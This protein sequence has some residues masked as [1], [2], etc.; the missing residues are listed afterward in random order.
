MKPAALSTITI[1]LCLVAGPPH[2]FAQ[3]SSGSTGVDGALNVTSNMTLNLPP[4]G[5]FNFTTISVSNGATLTFNRNPLNTPVYMLATGDVNISGIIDVGGKN[6]N[7]IAPGTGG[8][9]GFDGGFAALQ[10]FPDGDGQGPGGGR[11]A[12]NFG[13]AF[14]SAGGSGANTNV[15]GNTLLSP[16]V[17]GSG[18]AGGFAVGFRGGGGGGGAI[19]VGSSTRVT[20][21]STGL[22]NSQGG[23]GQ[24]GGSGGAIRLVAPVVDGSGRL[25]VNAGR[26]ELTGNYTG[27]PGRT[28]ID[29][30][31][32][33]AHGN[34]TLSGKATRGSQMFVFPPG[35][36]RLDIIHA[37]GREI[38]EGTNAP[39]TVNLPVGA[40]TNQIVRIQARGFTNDIPIRVRITP[41]NA[42]SA[43]FDGVITNTGNP[44]VG[45]VTVSLP[46]DTVCYLHVWTR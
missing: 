3:F 12:L 5:I 10:G 1:G 24:G 40:S 32:R 33:F 17:G 39:V 27:S 25:D 13:A 14:A 28:R 42:P 36:R 41:E 22:I 23:S 31:D 4:N 45:E 44:S 18:G 43:T 38:P 2:A 29:S 11:P 15:Y 21:N 6:R 7:G 16:L 26:G 46:V 20:I 19:L 37:A 35:N 30:I 34:L 8:P 9:G